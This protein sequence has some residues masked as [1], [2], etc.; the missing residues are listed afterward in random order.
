MLESVL[1]QDLGHP[2]ACHLY[3]HATERTEVPAKAVE[4]AELLGPS[5]PGASHIQHMPSHTFN[6][7]GRWGESVRGNLA[8]WHS[9]LKAEHGMGFAIYPSHNLHML[10]F[11]ASN[12][13]QGGVALQAARDYA[14]L[15][16]DGQ[17][18][19][20][21]VMWRFGRFDEMLDMEDEAPDGVI[22]RGLW[23]AAMGYAH[24]RQG[25]DQKARR[26]LSG[27]RNAA[28]GADEDLTFAGTRRM[29]CSVSSPV[30]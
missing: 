15:M 12:D 25:D 3:I 26:L 9:D 24:L 30:S 8:A 18:Y 2:G 4:C 6:R 29:P 1:D 22:F 10:L 19:T 14:E 5:I 17:F 27:V 20:V 28:E 21:L 16:D 7:V 11:A 13:A 23:D